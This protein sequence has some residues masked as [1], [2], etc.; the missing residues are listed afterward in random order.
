MSTVT[1]K[2]SMEVT[3]RTKMYC[4]LLQNSSSH[5]DS[6]HLMKYEDTR[7]ITF[8][9][10]LALY[11]Q[12]LTI[13]LNGNLSK[14]IFTA[15]VHRSDQMLCKDTEFGKETTSRKYCECCDIYYF[16]LHQHIQ[17]LQHKMFTLTTRNYQRPDSMIASINCTGKLVGDDDG[18]KLV[19]DDDCR[20]LVNYSDTDA[21]SDQNS[22]S[23]N[24]CLFTGWPQFWRKK[25]K[26]FSRMTRM[27]QH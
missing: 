8:A 15:A 21:G 23:D 6:S 14:G 16:S 2:F 19:K 13:S 25:F 11:K 9:P 3:I 17:G 1:L 22:F 12:F 27:D 4:I 10:H 20:K 7:S 26:D 5:R 18:H 24:V